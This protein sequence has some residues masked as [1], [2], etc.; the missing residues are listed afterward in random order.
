MQ[1][2]ATVVLYL[3]YLCSSLG[4]LVAAVTAL[5]VAIQG[6]REGNA[7]AKELAEHRLRCEP[8][9]RPAPAPPAPA[10]PEPTPLDKDRPAV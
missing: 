2:V 3:A 10:P 6:R 4:A 1:N 7:M 5:I 9:L 8:L